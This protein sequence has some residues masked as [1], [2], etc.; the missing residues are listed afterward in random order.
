MYL[1]EIN[2]ETSQLSE[3]ILESLQGVLKKAMVSEDTPEDTE[4][5]IT[6]VND[7]AI[8]SLNKEYRGKDKPT[9]VLSFALNEGEE[10]IFGADIPNTLGDIIISIDRARLQ[11][12]EYEHS[13]EREVC[14]LAV[15]GFLHLKGYLHESEEEEKVMFTR[16]KEILEAYGIQR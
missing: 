2:D 10:E 1:I 7:E 6:I 8:Q 4:I 14:F 3:K 5:S 9:D 11:A 12:E 16:Q 13:L 15:H